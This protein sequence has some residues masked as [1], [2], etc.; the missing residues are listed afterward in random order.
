MNKVLIYKKIKLISVISV[1]SQSG[2]NK[3]K[4]KEKVKTNKKEKNKEKSRKRLRNKKNKGI[5]PY[6]E[7]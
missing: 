3:K 2:I 5:D 1:N 4:E 7:Q 6:F